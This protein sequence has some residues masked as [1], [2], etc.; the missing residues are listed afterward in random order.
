[1]P[2]RCAVQWIYTGSRRTVKSWKEERRKSRNRMWGCVISMVSRLS[3][4]WITLHQLYIRFQCK[5]CSTYSSHL[6]SLYWIKPFSGI[7]EWELRQGRES[8]GDPARPS[9]I[10]SKH[11]WGVNGG[12]ESEI[13]FDD[14][15]EWLICVKLKSGYRE[16]HGW[17]V[18][19]KFPFQQPPYCTPSLS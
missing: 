11:C 17:F 10:L 1:M 12:R 18:S 6:L 5:A 4:P 15:D 14:F 19:T 8:W 13:R 16:L 3:E 2:S 7:S 9:R